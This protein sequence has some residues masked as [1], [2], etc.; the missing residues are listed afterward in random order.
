M[1]PGE[2]RARVIF[3]ALCVA[4]LLGI[5]GC[6]PSRQEAERRERDELNHER[7]EMMCAAIFL[8]AIDSPRGLQPHDC[9]FFRSSAC[10]YQCGAADGGTVAR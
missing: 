7:A 4:A 8:A 5:W 3:S 1:R 6:G 10:A 9:E 2:F